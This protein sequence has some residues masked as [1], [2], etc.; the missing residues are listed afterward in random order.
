[1]S[2]NAAIANPSILI[3]GVPV[4][5]QAEYD[6]LAK[7]YHVKFIGKTTNRAELLAAMK[8]LVSESDR[9]FDALVTLTGV[10]YGKRDQEFLS[11]LGPSLKFFTAMGAGYDSVDMA[12]LN[13]IGAWYCN[14]PT[15]PSDGTSTSAVV[16]ILACIHYLKQLDS[17]VRKGLWTKGIKPC[18]VAAGFTIG[19]LGMGRIGKLTRD[20]LS[21][22]RFNIIYHNRT[23]LSP[24]E[25]KGAKY[26]SFDELLAKSQL[27]C[28]HASL[29]TDTHHLLSKKEF[30]KLTPGVMIVNVARGPIVDEEAL[31]DAMK[32]D[33]VSYAGLDVFEHEPKV[34]PYL[35]ESERTTLSPHWGWTVGLEGEL[36]REALANLRDWI[37]TGN[38]SN[39][40]NTPKL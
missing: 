32:A 19:I 11:I 31:V 16:H 34:H 28:V 38:P 30:E 23:R 6:Q 33:I 5:T 29:S 4:E 8:K 7:E 18:P 22:L 27:I 1:M 13:R 36:E 24:E 14:T 25:E 15:A 12:Y 39:G 37:Q 26:V 2:S 20:K 10:P 35:L 17:N 21:G 3:V 9:E 40:V